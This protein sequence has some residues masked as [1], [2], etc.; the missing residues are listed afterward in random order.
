MSNELKKGIL[1]TDENLKKNFI[2]F[3]KLIKRINNLMINELNTDYNIH[4]IIY[5][6]LTSI[7]I[8]LFIVLLVKK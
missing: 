5:G 6:I 1:H 4:Y 2:S 3:L 8:I 7:I